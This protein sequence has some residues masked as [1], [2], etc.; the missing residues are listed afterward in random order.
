[1]KYPF[2]RV[3]SLLTAEEA[4]RSSIVRDT[5]QASKTEGEGQTSRLQL[6]RAGERVEDAPVTSKVW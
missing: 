2:H 3:G 1:M 6:V 5:L 4:Q